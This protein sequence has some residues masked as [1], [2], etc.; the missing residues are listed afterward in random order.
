LLFGAG[1]FLA[2]RASEVGWNVTTAVNLSPTGDCVL[3][4]DQAAGHNV[5]IHV[6][7]GLDAAEWCAAAS[8]QG[9]H[10]ELLGGAGEAEICSLSHGNAAGIVW[11]T[12][13]AIYGTALCQLLE[14][15]QGGD[16]VT[17]A[18]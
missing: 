17:A 8:A 1:G 4:P 15:P 12:G 3:Q 5:A 13:E 10:R 9:W 14:S 11:D 2:G 6:S 18:P 16:W 7:G